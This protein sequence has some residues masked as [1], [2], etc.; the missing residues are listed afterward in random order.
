MYIL[1]CIKGQMD[2]TRPS[3]QLSF[4]IR[5]HIY[6]IPALETANVIVIIINTNNN[7]CCCVLVVVADWVPLKQTSLGGLL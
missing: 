3:N 4:S 6:R 1:I 7:N 5:S 2:L